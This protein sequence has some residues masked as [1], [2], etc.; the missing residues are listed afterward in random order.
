MIFNA[1]WKKNKAL[2]ELAAAKLRALKEQ[3]DDLEEICTAMKI[4]LVRL[5]NIT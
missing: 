4:I 3:V 2:E 5:S 1:L